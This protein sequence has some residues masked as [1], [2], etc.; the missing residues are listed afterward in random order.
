MKIYSIQFSLQTALVATIVLASTEEHA[1]WH[2]DRHSVYARPN[3]RGPSAG[4]VSKVN[5]LVVNDRGQFSV[6][7]N[8]TRINCNK[9][10]SSYLKLITIKGYSGAWK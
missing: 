7:F 3:G 6:A 10:L 4:S 5:F 1:L 8:S 9:I 2:S